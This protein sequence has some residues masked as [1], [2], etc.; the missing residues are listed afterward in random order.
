MSLA[1]SIESSTMWQSNTSW[2]TW[3]LDCRQRP[4]GTA[5][6]LRSTSA[7]LPEPQPHGGND[8]GDSGVAAS[9]QTVE[10]AS[11]TLARAALPTD[12]G[13]PGPGLPD[14]RRAVV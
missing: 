7:W 9:A 6:G 5:T 4:P 14:D 1:W 8:P 3:R 2:S 10:L 13:D 11:Q 12:E